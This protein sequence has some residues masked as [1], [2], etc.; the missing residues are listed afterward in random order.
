MIYIKEQ[1]RVYFEED[2][3]GGVKSITIE[4][5][6]SV[7]FERF[8]EI[9]SILKVNNNGSVTDTYRISDHM[10]ESDLIVSLMRNE[11]GKQVLSNY[12]VVEVE[13]I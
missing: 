4:P 10:I 12:I 9:H 6:P 2:I 3:Y 13:Y 7:V 11:D 8:Y 1:I 5:S